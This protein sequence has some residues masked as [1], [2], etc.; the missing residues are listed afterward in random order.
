MASALR[1]QSID[2]ARD[3]NVCIQFRRDSYFCSFGAGEAF[4][5]A[6]G[7]ATGYLDRLRQRLAAL[8]EGI[9]HA[10]RGNRIVGQIEARVASDAAGGYVNLFY[11]TAEERGRGAGDELHAHVS[12]SSC[13]PV[14]NHEPFEDRE[15]S[16]I[17]GDHGDPVRRGN[18]SDLASTTSDWQLAFS[19]RTRSCAESVCCVLSYGPASSTSPRKPCSCRAR[20]GSKSHCAQR[21]GR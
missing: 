18:R 9:V 6:T 3:A 1:F 20:I 7:G 4:D 5:P 17:G 11:L 8:P 15:V 10:W 21:V 12:A 13:H 2:L 19:R 14:L 16:D